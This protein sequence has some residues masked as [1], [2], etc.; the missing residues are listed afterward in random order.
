MI[1]Q[2]R[3]YILPCAYSVLPAPMASEAATR[4]LLAIGVQESGFEHRHQIGGPAV[5]FFQFEQAG[6]VRGVLSHP[7]TRQ[8]IRD[9]LKALR[10]S[11]DASTWSCFDAIR[12]N[13]VLACVFARLLLWTLPDPLPTDA[14]TGWSQYRAA[15]RPGKP[16]L[17]DWSESWRKAMEV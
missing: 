14:Q 3:R 12:H 10:Y 9:A 13:D 11:P 6:G 5:G 7:Q 8:P 16:R 4:L 17:S 1:E 2:V 15:W